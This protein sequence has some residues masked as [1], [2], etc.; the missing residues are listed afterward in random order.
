M[1]KMTKIQLK[2]TCETKNDDN[3]N[4]N[5]KIQLSG[6]NT[7]M[8]ERLELSDKNYKGIT[9][10]IFPQESQTLL[11]QRLNVLHS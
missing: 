1:L 9:I 10:K 3:G 8:T 6:A 7:K 2:I 4:L 11:K 5:E